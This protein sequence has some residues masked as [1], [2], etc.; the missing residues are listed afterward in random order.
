MIGVCIAINIGD[1]L[2]ICTSYMGY[3]QIWLNLPRDEASIT[4]A[5]GLTLTITFNCNSSQFEWSLTLEAFNIHP[6]HSHKTLHTY[7]GH[8]NNEPLTSGGLTDLLC[9]EHRSP[10]LLPYTLCSKCILSMAITVKD[11][12]WDYFGNEASMQPKMLW[13]QSLCRRLCSRSLPNT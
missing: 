6:K 13:E 1:W 4:A 8:Q 3:S 9:Q 11:L 12:E 2:K 5:P 7:W 10:W